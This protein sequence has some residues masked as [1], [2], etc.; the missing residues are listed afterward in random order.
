MFTRTC[1]G[2][3]FVLLPRATDS[4]ERYARMVRDHHPLFY[5]RTRRQRRMKPFTPYPHPRPYALLGSQG[6]TITRCNSEG[7]Q[8]T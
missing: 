2:E 5:A 1:L 8:Y 4:T 7:I 6:N 3:D